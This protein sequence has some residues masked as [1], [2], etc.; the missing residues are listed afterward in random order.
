MN[1]AHDRAPI[2]RDAIAVPLVHLE[3]AKFGISL[4]RNKR[5]TEKQSLKKYKLPIIP[6][7]SWRHEPQKAAKAGRT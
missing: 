1:A 7:G 5:L 2:T 4:A 3:D 6:Q